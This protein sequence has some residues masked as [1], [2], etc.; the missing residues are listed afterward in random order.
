VLRGEDTVL[1]LL[2]RGIG[3]ALWKVEI[4]GDL[5][6]PDVNAVFLSVLKQPLDVFR[7][8]NTNIS[9]QEDR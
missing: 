9:A 6:S 3:S 5:D 2:V 8:T 1:D 7:K 4:Q